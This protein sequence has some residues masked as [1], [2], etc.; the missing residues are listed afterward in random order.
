MI[1]EKSEVTGNLI[2]DLTSTSAKTSCMVH[3]VGAYLAHLSHQRNTSYNTGQDTGPVAKYAVGL[4]I[5]ENWAI[6][7]EIRAG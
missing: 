2:L 1:L 4:T 5:L 3:G 7:P 6:L